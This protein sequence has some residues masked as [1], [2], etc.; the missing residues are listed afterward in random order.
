[1][2]ITLDNIIDEVCQQASIDKQN[3]QNITNLIRWVNFTVNDICNR[4]PW[5]FLH[6]DTTLTSV[7]DTTSSGSIVVDATNGQRTITGT[8]TSFVSTDVGRYIQFSSS[9]D[10]YKIDSVQSS[11]ALTLATAYAPDTETGLG[12]TI[13]TYY[14]NLPADCHKVF[15]IRQARTP[16]KLVAIDPR[17]FDTIRPRQT[18]TGLPRAYYMY[19]YNNPTSATGQT[20][21][22]T[23]EPIPDAAMIFDVRYQKRPPAMS[24]GTD[25]CIIPQNHIQVVVDGTLVKAYQYQ[26]NPS[27]GGQKA[28]YE[29]GIAQMK[30]DMPPTLD[31]LNV[32][33]PID[34]QYSP[35]YP[36]AYPDQYGFPYS[37]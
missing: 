7:V 1:M 33:Q 23:F 37:F 11:T 8:G 27:T 34:Q 19:P 3:Q 24:V 9:Y 36:V 30:K 28:L 14:Y 12:F 21:A 5:P 2:A 31:I 25:I 17:N 32:I 22:L 16:T 6:G 18:T 10:W 35:V 4:Y 15:D 26:N 29:D 20:Y 13:R